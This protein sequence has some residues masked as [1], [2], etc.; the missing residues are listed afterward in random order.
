MKQFR[1]VFILIAIIAFLSSCGNRVTDPNSYFSIS[2]TEAKKAYTHSDALQITIQNKRNLEVEG[3]S[4]AID[5]EQ[6]ANSEGIKEVSIPLDGQKMGVRKLTAVIQAEGEMYVVS[7]SIKMVA[8]KTPKLY[9][10]KV[11]ETYPHDINAFTQGLEFENDTLY[12]STGQRKKSTLRKT[13]YQTGEVLQKEKIADQF[14][15]EG[16]TIMDDKIYQLTW[17]RNTGFVYDLATMKK[18]GGFVYNESKEG[19][20]LCNDGTTIYKSDG[21]EKI[22]SLNSSTLTEDGYIEIYTNKSKIPRVNE[23]EWVDG[24]IYANIWQQ[25]AIAIVDPETGAVEG[26]INMKG[27]QEQVTQHKTLDVL[28]GI[29]YKGEPNIL[30]VTGKNWDKLFK[31]EIVAQ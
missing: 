21:T 27:L 18:T 17:Q 28:N 25:D 20:G 22:W 15:A 13:N 11:L 9:N 19:W 5:L 1:N 10:Y 12:E 7:K 26:V 16:I 24:K 23:L 3:V 31:I 29:A 8:A 6:M 14:F 30:Y 4:Y 2:I